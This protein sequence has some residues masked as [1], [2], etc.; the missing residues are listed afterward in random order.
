MHRSD[1]WIA[2]RVATRDGRVVPVRATARRPQWADLPASAREAIAFRLGT[3]VIRATS[4]GIGFTPGFASRLDLANGRRV[5]VK[6]ASDVDDARYGWP[7]SEAYREESRKLRA[8]P[9]ELPAPALLWTEDDDIAGMQWVILCFEYV[10]GAPPRRPWQP[11]ELR[12]VTEA[13]ARLAPLVA[14]APAGLDLPLFAE[15]FPEVEAW[16]ARVTE[17]DKSSRWLDQVSGLARES[18]T[19]CAGTAVAHLDLRDD[20]ILIGR[21]GRVWICDWN[22]PLL[23]APWLDLVTLLLGAAGD[24]IDADAVL[25]THPLTRDVE[26]RSID[27]WLAT[28]WLYFTTAMERPVPTHSP[29][30][31]DHQAWYAEATE[32][33]LRHRLSGR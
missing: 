16:L 8:L 12:L 9:S 5:F 23:G 27:A 24:G 30:L 10:D 1:D 25:A 2:D 19:R 29:H 13:L 22:W 18:L 21:S 14:E 3:E 6:A 31:R 20:N 28:L 17:R 15:E 32:D 11:N 26:Q 7:L 33:W 4:T